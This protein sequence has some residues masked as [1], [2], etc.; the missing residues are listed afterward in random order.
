MSQRLCKPIFYILTLMCI[1][2]ITVTEESQTVHAFSQPSFEYPL[3]T[4]IS[5][6][7]IKKVGNDPFY[8]NGKIVPI[9]DEMP[10]PVILNIED[11]YLP[12]V[13]QPEISDYIEDMEHLNTGYSYNHIEAMKAQAVA[14]RSYAYSQAFD[15]EPQCL[16]ASQNIN[17]VDVLCAVTDSTLDQAWDP[18]SIISTRTFD[19]VT[20]T[21]NQFIAFYTGISASTGITPS[22][23][24]YTSD[25]SGD[26]STQG[27]Y[28]GTNNSI[29][30]PYL[31]S[32][33]DPIQSN[34]TTSTGQGLSQARAFY[35][36]RGKDVNGLTYPKWT[37]NKILAHYYTKVILRDSSKSEP[38]KLWGDY[39]WNMLQ[40]YSLDILNNHYWLPTDE[41]R[42]ITM[43]VQNTGTVPW[44]SNL[45]MRVRW[46]RYYYGS[47]DASTDWLTA[48]LDT[49]TTLLP[50]SDLLIYPRVTPPRSI[51]YGY[52]YTYSYCA[53][54]DFYLTDDNKRMQEQGWETQ[55]WCNFTLLRR[56]PPPDRAPEPAPSCN[57]KN[58]PTP[59]K[60]QPV[61]WSRV[62]HIDPID[63]IWH[64]TDS[65]GQRIDSGI[66]PQS[67]SS[68]NPQLM[69]ND[70]VTG[71]NFVYVKTRQTFPYDV[72][73]VSEET[74]VAT[75]LY[76]PDHSHLALAVPAW[77]APQSTFPVTFSITDLVDPSG[78]LGSGIKAYTLTQ[79]FQG[80]TSI[81]L[82]APG[83]P[84]TLTVQ[85][86][87]H[88]SIGSA[89]HG[90]QHTF[91][92]QAV[93]YAGNL[94]SISQVATI[95]AQAP[96]ITAAFLPAWT[97]QTT[98]NFNWTVQDVGS[99]I[100]Q[101]QLAY[102]ANGGAWTPLPVPAMSGTP[103]DVNA[104][105]SLSNL[106]PETA[107]DL[108]WTLTDVF[109]NT[110]QELQTIKTDF[111]A[112]TSWM[113]DPAAD[114][115]PDP[116]AV[117]PHAW[118]TLA[119]SG[120]DEPKNSVLGGSG[121]AYY[122]IQPRRGTGIST[123]WERIRPMYALNYPRSD[124]LRFKAHPQTSYRFQIRAVDYAG[125]TGTWRLSPVTYHF[126][127]GYDGYFEA[128]FPLFRPNVTSPPAPA[129]G[130]L[131]RLPLQPYPTPGN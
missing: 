32:V 58:C 129:S 47:L 40:V 107:Y 46:H 113:I 124:T 72:D 66:T 69:P 99:G 6:L 80:T 118:T 109:G 75:L 2:L 125:N 60:A 51:Y 42:T 59:I 39:R 130:D 73:N 10:N 89:D 41:T 95:D 88:A 34:H 128:L 131:I 16:F 122:E 48:P 103:A 71:E 11:E 98:L 111:L 3:D 116:V 65:V 68:D 23:A 27:Y 62:S 120:N 4:L 87:P 35:W 28:A 83:T 100:Q 93:D 110:R 84:D 50:G 31:I 19:A 20:L 90:H 12:Y 82:A 67:A 105:T 25:H 57:E 114:S 121:I 117:L 123:V 26:Y 126:G 1:Y 101:I 94:A 91:T 30:I 9:D 29:P 43:R 97:N 96:T 53:E 7:R 108:R 33:Y 18:N 79:E 45:G 85:A 38:P 81:V 63:Y 74:L 13:V 102:R 44:P 64:I 55:Y 119:F 112:P 86:Q 70:L 37:V 61:A 52:N 76:D 115:N 56:V 15:D 36:S 8:E 54:F 106:Q 49:D 5:V 14:A 77:V 24:L 78:A 17:G 104:S 127:S 22:L 21:K 92:L